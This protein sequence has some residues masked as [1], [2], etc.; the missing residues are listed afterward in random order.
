MTIL[1]KVKFKGNLHFIIYMV[2]APTRLEIITKIEEFVNEIMKKIN[3][4]EITY[5]NDLLKY[6]EDV[7]SKVTKELEHRRRKVE[8]REKEK[9]KKIEQLTSLILSLCFDKSITFEELRTKVKKILKT[10]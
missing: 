10:I 4:N 8:E 5:F 1:N 7:K 2:R 6:L 3:I 9:E